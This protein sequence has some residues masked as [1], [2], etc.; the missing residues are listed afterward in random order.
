M[1]KPNNAVGPQVRNKKK[2]ARGKLIPAI[3]SLHWRLA[4]RLPHSILLTALIIRNCW[5][6]TSITSTR[7]GPISNG[8]QHGMT[9][10][11]MRFLQLA[12]SELRSLPVVWS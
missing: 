9:V 2:T 7:R 10:Y 12:V 3:P 6:Q 1:R 5:G 11:L 8:I 4:S